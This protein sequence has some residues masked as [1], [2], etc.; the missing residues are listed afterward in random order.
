MQQYKTVLGIRLREV[1]QLAPDQG[2]IP[3]LSS[4]AWCPSSIASSQ[5][6][7]LSCLSPPAGLETPQG[8][9]PGSVPLGLLGA[10]HSGRCPSGLQNHLPT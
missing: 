7:A 4:N 2:A 1:K 6:R 3:A 5:V 10:R 9:G 8:Q